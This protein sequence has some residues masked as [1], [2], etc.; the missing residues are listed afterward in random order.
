M[1]FIGLVILSS[2]GSPCHVSY[3]YHPWVC[4]ITSILQL[5]ISAREHAKKTVINNVLTCIWISV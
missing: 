3:K 4:H 5:I 1:H 2:V